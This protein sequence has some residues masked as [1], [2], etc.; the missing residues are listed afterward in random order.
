MS[1][2]SHNGLAS[3]CEA[4]LDQ[5][6]CGTGRIRTRTERDEFAGT[7]GRETGTCRI[8]HVHGGLCRL[9]PAPAARLARHCHVRR[10]SDLASFAEN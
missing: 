9:C 4:T 7:T 5:L 3:H 6:G 8:T 1:S 10:R 2:L